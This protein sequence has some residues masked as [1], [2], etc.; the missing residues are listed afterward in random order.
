MGTDNNYFTINRELWNAKT[1]HHIN[2]EFYDVEG[3][4]KG[5]SSLKPAELT[6]LGDV[7]GKSIL[8]LQCHFGQDTLSLARMGAKV[9]GVDISD[10]SI[11][12]ARL[13]SAKLGLESEF[14][15]C[16]IYDL[17]L[18]SDKQFDIVFTTYGVLGW[19]PD[20]DKWASV[21]S[22]FLKKGGTFILV[23]FHPVVWM[24]DADFRNIEFAYFN[25]EPIIETQ[26]GTY[27]DRDAPLKLKEVGWNHGLGEVL[28]SLLEHGL[29]IVEFREYD[30]SPYDCFKNMEKVGEGKFRIKHL[31]DKIPMM[32][33]VKAVKGKA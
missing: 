32:Y 1:G 23:E 22:R 29:E 7:K 21:V 25:R 17:P 15:C 2:S 3:F 16:N 4:V 8:H 6:M 10:K 27:A 13:L 12:E 33:A 24:F 5:A 14:I 28:G 9:T 31:G 18:H 19:L 11:D 20:M 26:E 30:H